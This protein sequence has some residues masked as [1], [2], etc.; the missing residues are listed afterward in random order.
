MSRAVLRIAALSAALWGL[1]CSSGSPSAEA[2][3]GGGSDAGNG[4]AGASANQGGSASQSGS[5]GRA[6]SGA[7]GTHGDFVAAFCGAARSCCELDGIDAT[8][9]QDCEAE[10]ERQFDV[11]E[12]V[13]RG[14]VVVTTELASCVAGLEELAEV[15]V[16]DATALSVCNSAFNGTVAPGGACVDALDCEQDDDA[17][18]CI[19]LQSSDDAADGT[20][21]RLTPA[22]LGEPCMATVGELPYRLTYTTEGV[23]PPLAYCA[24]ASSLYCS[25]ETGTC[26]EQGGVGTPCTTRQ[27]CR[28][29]LVCAETCRAPKQL[30]ESCEGT[31]E[32]GPSASCVAGQCERGRF[33]SPQLCGG[34]LN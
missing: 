12:A 2:P 34:D 30:G 18:T 3:S 23:E 9:L 26:Q 20:C 15:C 27:A 17:V 32:C 7:A 19:R 21:R 16:F 25:F 5:G 6:G 1:A 33:A 8:G 13:A 31:A 28:A 24:M 14:T 11:L 22:A 29:G 10:A 4:S